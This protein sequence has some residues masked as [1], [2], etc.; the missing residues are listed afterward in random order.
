MLKRVVDIVL[1]LVGLVCLSPILLVA[2]IAVVVESGFPVL[3]LQRRVGRGCQ[4]FTILKFRSM[5]PNPSAKD[6]VAAG[7]Q[8]SREALAERRKAFQTTSAG[9]SRLTRVGRFLRRCYIDE[10]PQLVNVIKGDMSL[11]GP[12]PDTPV[13]EVDYPPALWRARHTVRPGI[14][15]L[16]QVC[17]GKNNTYRRRIMLDIIYARRPTICRDLWIMWRTVTHAV[18]QGSY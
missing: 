1:G 9:D 16:A 7:E 4:P 18:F 15:G 10:L 3:F 17:G 8:L 14:T 5:R 12:R 13:Q 6:V 11:V 2:A